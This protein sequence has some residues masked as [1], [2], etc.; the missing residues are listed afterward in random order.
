MFSL[1]FDSLIDTNTV[2][3]IRAKGYSR[4]PVYWGESPTFILGIL[5]VKSLIGVD[6]DKPRTLRQL[7]KEGVC[8]IR[9]PLYVRR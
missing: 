6:I 2:E 1:S 4:I 8:T 5:M 9:T 3:E 7:S